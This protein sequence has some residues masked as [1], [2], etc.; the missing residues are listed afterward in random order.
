MKGLSWI[1][2]IGL[3]VVLVY[4][5]VIS[6]KGVMS[7]GDK[8]SKKIQKEDQMVSVGQR[9]VKQTETK[10]T[11]TTYDKSS[12]SIGGTS[13]KGRKIKERLKYLDTIDEVKWWEVDDNTVYINFSPTP[14]DWNTI[15]Q[16]AALHGNNT[17]NFGVHVWALNNKGRGWRPGDSGYLGNTTARYGK[18]K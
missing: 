1:L 15:I 2:G 7:E 13:T 5:T 16:S 3:C 9:T 17:I 4:T 11:T 12:K 14:S 6:K 8:Q 18:I 10:K